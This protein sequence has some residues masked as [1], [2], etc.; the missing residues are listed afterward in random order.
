MTSALETPTP[1]LAEPIPGLTS[2]Q[3][4]RWLALVVLCVGQLMIV[5]DVTVVN[6]A[7]PVMQ[8]DLHFSQA[9]LAWVIN[10]YLIS[11][12][13]LLML[14]GRLGDVFGRRRLFLGGLTAFTTAS[15]LCGLSNSQ[16]LLIGARF[17]QGAGAAV[18]AS[19]VLGILVTLF[20]SARDRALA[21]S[22]Y[23]FVASAGGSIGLL[24]GGVLTEA[25]SWHWIFFINLPI[26]IA[27]GVL[28]AML[29]PEQPGIG[30]RQRLDLGGALLITAAPSLFVYTILQAADQGWAT[31][32]TAALGGAALILFAAFLLLESRIRDPLIPLR[33]FRSRTVAGANL[34]RALFAVGLFGVFFLGALYMQ[35][36]LGYSA[37]GTGLAFLPNNLTV[38]L[39]SLVLTRRVVAR[40]GARTT[41][42]A[43]LLLV[44]AA[45]GLFSRV[46]VQ[47]S[48]VVDVLPVMLLIGAGA[49]LIFMPSVNLAM[50][51]A[52]P[53]DSGIL[54][55]LTNVS[56][57]LGAA[58]G[59]AV[60]ASVSTSRT[61]AR[62]VDGASQSVALTAGYHAGLL[63]AMGCL[64]VAAAGAA[65]LLRPATPSAGVRMLVRRLII[66]LL[67]WRSGGSVATEWD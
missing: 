24:V 15:L 33:V 37:V 29:I 3:R 63:I 50:A 41:L 32:R 54:S 21:T 16:A 39:F 22:I 2:N 42:I 64:I 44:A 6:V 65:L 40:Y 57:Q 45:L 66:S 48:Y 49:G 14:A 12:G 60:L 1:R 35:R 13:G 5:L 18:I 58:I 9:S 36:V 31:A 43:G 62:L 67:G 52:G 11:F 20:E 7:L 26:G 51:G 38:G 59:V 19:M 4:R 53:R 8:R 10:G 47:G 56:L 17:L 30:V 27:A 61:N 28:A 34:I 55:G 23:A 46:P 25:L